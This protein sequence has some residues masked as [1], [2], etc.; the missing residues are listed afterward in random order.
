MRKKKD[1]NLSNLRKKL[2]KKGLNK[3]KKIK[4]ARLRKKSHVPKLQRMS[5]SESR[6]VLPRK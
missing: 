4:S 5:G 2:K 1:L 3:P 6:R